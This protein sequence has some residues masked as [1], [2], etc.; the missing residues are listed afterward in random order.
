MSAVNGPAK[1]SKVRLKWHV[2]PSIS[3][4]EEKLSNKWPEPDFFN[5]M[6]V[7]VMFVRLVSIFGSMWLIVIHQCSARS[8]CWY[9][10]QQDN[11]P[12]ITILVTIWLSYHHMR[13][14]SFYG[15]CYNRYWQR[16]INILMG[17]SY[18]LLIQKLVVG[19]M[20]PCWTINHQLTNLLYFV[21]F[22][23]SLHVNTCRW[24]HYPCK[25]IKLTDAC[26]VTYLANES[27]GAVVK[28]QT[29][30][31]LHLRSLPRASNNY[32]MGFMTLVPTARERCFCFTLEEVSCC[33]PLNRRSMIKPP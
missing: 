18:W 2:R 30:N 20:I 14:D 26:K 6:T 9:W 4:F 21:V 3:P 28:A 8:T 24:Q 32:G 10:L 22:W 16:F 19:Q 29:G 7:A 27:C 33:P 23:M 25:W 12:R 17:D 13:E 1:L 5:C 11:Y 15:K 31:R